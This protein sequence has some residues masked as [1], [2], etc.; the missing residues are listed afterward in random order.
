MKKLLKKIIPLLLVL[1]FMLAGCTTGTT[2][3]STE[4]STSN[5]QVA[6]QGN[7]KVFRYAEEAEPTI[8]DPHKSFNP[9]SLDITYAVYEG[10]TRVYDGEVLP[11]MAESWDVSEDGLTY[12]FHLRDAKWSDGEPVTAEDFTY[13][14]ERLFNPDTL[15]DYGNFAVYFEGGEDYWEGK[16]TDF[17]TVGV[18]ALDDKTLECKLVVPKKYFLNLMGFGAFHP[19]RQDYIEK[20]G[21]SYGSDPEKAV[22]N[23]PFI[24]K[25]WKHEESLLE[26]KNDDYWDKD[27]IH[28]DEVQISIVNNPATRVNMYETDQLDFTQLTK[29][30]I[31]SYEKEN[32]VNIQPNSSIYWLQYQVNHKDPEKAAF[33]GNKNFRKALGWAIDRQA[34]ADSVLA[35]GSLPATRLVPATIQGLN[36]KHAEEYSIGEEYFPTTANIEKANEYLDLAL[37]EI[38]KKKEEMPTFEILVDDSESARLITEA[39]QDMFD[40][41]LG[42]KMEIKAVTSSQKWDEMGNN[43]FDIMY[44]GFGPDFNDPVNYLDTWTLDG[45]YNVMGWENKEYEEL[46]RFINT[47]NDNQARADAI[48][49]A[50]KIFLDEVVFNPI[51]FGTAVYTQKDTVK[52][53]LRDST[54]MDINYIYVDIVNE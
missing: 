44:A 53:L 4:E 49:K 37:Q 6:E 48:D 23:G 2:K 54:G 25:E 31:P 50:E 9:I 12:T 47:T 26:V 27:N 46:V 35:D 19:V 10:L 51:F 41:N 21:E 43:N 3:S 36:K 40:K 28:L 30:D 33:L 45:G 8:L 29:T 24:L 32:K 22:Y 13:S 20:Y 1:S 14:F 17:S 34:I 39:I 11:G 5:E 18:K 52:G 42:V 16:T 38:G 7:K 15:S